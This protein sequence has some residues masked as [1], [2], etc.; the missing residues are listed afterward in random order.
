VARAVV[1]AR[2]DGGAI[3][4]TVVA[5]GGSGAVCPEAARVP[6]DQLLGL[7]R[8][9]W[10][11]SYTRLPSAAAYDTVTLWLGHAW[12]RDPGG[13]LVTRASPRLFVLS[14]AGGSG[15]SQVLEATGLLSPA[16]YGLDLEPSFAGLVATVSQEHATVFI[17]E[18]DI[19]F[20][21]GARKSAVRAVINGGYTRAG[22]VLNGTG[23][24]ATRT[25]VFGAMAVAGLDMLE[26]NAGEQMKATLSR[27]IRI[28]MEPAP[29]DDLPRDLDE[30]A[31]SK[32][33]EIRRWMAVWAGQVAGQVAKAVP[34]VPAGIH[35]RPA[36][37]WRPL[38]AV[39]D[40]AGGDWPE[41]ARAACR[42]LAGAP[43]RDETVRDRFA[44]FAA[45]MRG[46]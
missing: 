20:G 6:G 35:G 17:D 36:Q 12:M 22:T 16:Y 28:R 23:S 2:G 19:L 7:V 40:A 18:A 39:A 44:G 10:Y 30:Y 32:A 46:E 9:C 25:G 26:K 13:V 4:G 42:E 1:A 24:K 29:A 11:G 27:G 43:S 33:G 41:R 5:P 15:K 14:R 8:D 45:Q 38:L 34:E 37:I 31:E 21:A 3:T